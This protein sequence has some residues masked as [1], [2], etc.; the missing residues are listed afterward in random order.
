VPLIIMN[1]LGGIVALIWLICLGQWRVIFAGLLSFLCATFLISFAL[2]PGF[3]FGLVAVAVSSKKPDSRFVLVTS[4]ALSQLY[5][6]AVITAW[7]SIV[8]Y[9]CL[10]MATPS[11]LL[12]VL[13]FGYEVATGPWAALAA[14]DQ[15]SDSRSNSVFHVLF[16]SVGYV[17]AAASPWLGGISVPTSFIILAVTMAVS[18]VFQLV[19]FIAEFSAE[20]RERR[21][22]GLE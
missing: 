11:S 19:I 10:R 22:L 9:F 13:L 1:L 12:P 6:T 5:T 3:L 8:L 2:A 7:G 17:I 14:R 21:S 16:L 4:A 20:R 15:Q 18:W